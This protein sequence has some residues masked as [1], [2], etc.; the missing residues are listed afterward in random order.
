MPSDNPISDIAEGTTKGIL[1]WSLD[2]ITFFLQKLEHRELA[3]IEEQKTIDIVKEQ[4]LSGESKFYGKYIKDKKF[5]FLARLGLSLRKMER[6]KERRVNLRDKIF[7]KYSVEGLHLA[8]FVENGIL[9]RY[10]G[11]LIEGLVSIEKLERDIEDILKNIE[12]YTIFVKWTSKKA[13]I[14]K[15]VD[16]MINANSPCIFIISGFGTAA[17]IVQESIEQFKVIMKDYDFERVSSGEKEIL[18]FKRRTN[19]GI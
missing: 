18:F 12:K 16:I 7:K 11:I 15:K 5:L 4:Y 2:K 1:D 13:E 3:F 17:K 14:I 9:N 10:V 6:D 19:L 8:E